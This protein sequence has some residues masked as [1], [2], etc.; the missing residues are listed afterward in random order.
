MPYDKKSFPRSEAAH[1]CGAR[2]PGSIDKVA[3]YGPQ[4]PCK[5]FVLPFSIGNRSRPSA[6]DA[7]RP[8]SRHAKP[9]F[10]EKDRSCFVS[11]THNVRVAERAALPTVDQSDMRG[12]GTA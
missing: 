11:I 9:L 10:A 7:Q 12:L 5:T 3:G 4:G 2:R 8:C 1:P 6:L